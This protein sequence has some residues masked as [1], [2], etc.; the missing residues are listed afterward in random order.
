[1]AEGLPQAK[2]GESINQIFE[3]RPTGR[4]GRGASDPNA[5]RLFSYL[6]LAQGFYYV[7]TALWDLFSVDTFQRVTGPKTDVWLVKT[8]GVLVAAI[9]GALIVA[10]YRR[11]ET[12]EIGLLGAGSAGGLAGIDAYY[13]AKRR[14]S[15]VYG[16]DALAELIFLGCWIYVLASRKRERR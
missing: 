1:M 3:A 15:A 13:V 9:G 4:Y 12:T 7:V 16:L 8:V 10:G 14:V 6:S 2:I 11:T 5:T